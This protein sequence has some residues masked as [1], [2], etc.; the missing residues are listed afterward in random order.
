MGYY[1]REYLGFVKGDTR[2]LD[3]STC[4]ASLADFCFWFCRHHRHQDID[5]RSTS[6][7]TPL[8]MAARAQKSLELCDFLVSEGADLEAPLSVFLTLPCPYVVVCKYRGDPNIAPDMWEFFSR[9]GTP[10]APM[11]PHTTG[12]ARTNYKKNARSLIGLRLSYY[13]SYYDDDDCYYC[14]YCCYYC[15]CCEQ[16]PVIIIT[17]Y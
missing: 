13:W 6:G 9:N 7:E 4:L 14:C 17:I 5:P 12:E 8:I 10:E 2:S 3:S 15:S 11:S 16:L 1:I